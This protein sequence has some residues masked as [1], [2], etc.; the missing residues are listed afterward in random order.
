[1]KTIILA[2]L[3][4]GGSALAAQAETFT[5]SGTT[6]SVNSVSVTSP[7]GTRTGGGYSESRGTVTY[8]GGKT[9]ES[10]ARCVGWSG[11]PGDIFSHGVCNLTDSAGTNSV[12]FRCLPDAK[13]TNEQSCVGG[14]WGTGGAYANRTGTLTWH[15]KDAADGKTSAYNGVGQ[16]DN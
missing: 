11:P 8:A 14:I 1:M 6:T 9:V 10:A 2:A 13:M 7:R 4:V 5:F 3:L 12:G 15:S 16:Y